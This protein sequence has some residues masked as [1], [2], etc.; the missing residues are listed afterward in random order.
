VNSYHEVARV[1]GAGV[2]EPLSNVVSNI[3]IGAG[4]GLDRDLVN[5]TTDA[6][7]LLGLCGGVVLCSQIVD[8]ASQLDDSIAR[9][10]SDVPSSGSRIVRD[11]L[12]NPVGYGGIAG[13]AARGRRVAGRRAQCQAQR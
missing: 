11:R 6:V 13:L 7:Y 3:R 12:T 10:N 2:L 5:D 8:L 4:N 1:N 9:L